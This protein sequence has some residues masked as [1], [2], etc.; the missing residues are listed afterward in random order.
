MGVGQVYVAIPNLLS[1]ERPKLT[2]RSLYQGVWR[3]QPGSKGRTHE[4]NYSDTPYR[5][6]KVRPHAL[7]QLYNLTR[8]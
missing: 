8:I 6:A 4:W 2:M 3:W 1:F 7:L 5:T